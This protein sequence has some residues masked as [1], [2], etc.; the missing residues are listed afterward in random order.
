MTTQD[1]EIIHQRRQ[2]WIY[3]E[4]HLQEMHFFLVTQKSQFCSNLFIYIPV[5]NLHSRQSAIFTCD[6]F[7]RNWNFFY[8]LILPAFVF[9][10]PVISSH[11]CQKPELWVVLHLFAFSATPSN[12]SIKY[13][14]TF[15]FLLFILYHL[16]SGSYIFPYNHCSLWNIPTFNFFLLFLGCIIL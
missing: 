12:M 3:V 15:I 5:I 8:Y 9:L 10:V 1:G 2:R 6:V 7:W 16:K 4:E 11:S 14:T 13:T